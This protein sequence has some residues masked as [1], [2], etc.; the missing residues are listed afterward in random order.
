MK[1]NKKQQKTQQWIVSL[2][3]ILGLVLG[4][5]YG[6]IIPQISVY[7]DTH[8]FEDFEGGTWYGGT[9]PQ[10]GNENALEVVEPDF[11]AVS[12]DKALRFEWEKVYHNQSNR[13]TR[14]SEVR[15]ERAEWERDIWESFYYYFPEEG[16][17][18]D[19]LGTV[20]KQWIAW[21]SD[22]P[23]C[24]KSFDLE[25]ANDAL[26][27]HVLWNDE[28][29]TSMAHPHDQAYL[30]SA[31][32]PK[33]TWVK[34]ELHYRFDLD[35]PDGLL[36][37]WM[38]DMPMLQLKDIQMGVG[39]N[40]YGP[41]AKYGPYVYNS[42]TYDQRFMYADDIKWSYTP[43][44]DHS[45]DVFPDH[46]IDE[47]AW[48][49]RTGFVES[50]HNLGENTV[51]EGIQNITFDVTP[52]LN[53]LDGC[54]GYMDAS[55]L[56]TSYSSM[57]MIVRLN[58]DGYFDV[59]NGSG[60]EADTS[61]AYEHDVTY[62]V[63]IE[64]DMATQTYS[65][66]VTDEQD[67]TYSL[68]TDY[69]YRTG[70]PSIDDIGQICLI[71]S[72][73][74]GQFKVNNHRVN[75]EA[76]PMDQE[77]GDEDTTTVIVP[78]KDNRQGIVTMIM[79]DGYKASTEYYKSAFEAN[80]LKGSLA[81]ITDWVDDDPEFWQEIVASGYF[82]VQSHS[83]SHMDLSQPSLDREVIEHEVVDSKHILQSLFPGQDVLGFVA[84]ENKSNGASDEIIIETYEAMRKGVR[85]FNSLSPSQPD[86]YNLMVQGVMNTASESTMN[87][88]LDTAADNG[89]WLIEMWHGVASYNPGTYNPVSKT[90]ADNH[91]AYMGDKQEQ[92]E[93]WVATFGEAVKYIRQRQEADITVEEDTSGIQIT[94]TDDLEDSIYN[95]EV[96]LRSEVPMDWEGVEIHHNGT[97]MQKNTVIESDGKNYVYYN[98]IPDQG[99]ITLS[100]GEYVEEPVEEPEVTVYVEEDFESGLIPNDVMT[101]Y[102]KE[103]RITV[104]E[105]TA[106]NHY[107][108]VE[109]A[110]E[111]TSD[112]HIDMPLSL[113]SQEVMIEMQLTYENLPAEGNIQ[114]KD[115]ENGT[116]YLLYIKNG[117]LM[118]TD[119]ATVC[120]L[121]SASFT[122][123]KL[124]MNLKTG[125]MTVAVDGAIVVEDYRIQ[126]AQLDDTMTL[127]RVYMNKTSQSAGGTLMIDDVTLKDEEA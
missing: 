55:T 6:G 85:G 107:L 61:V 106:G 35:S 43:I 105:S 46:T 112:A 62:H 9:E 54:I 36:E 97:L 53:Y 87:G 91:L 74:D 33:N 15:T 120:Q 44:F 65:V 22:V 67:R 31:D 117:R 76:A 100:Q 99:I 96:T 75:G 23:D 10:I 118:T 24:N 38:N 30:V 88:W 98:T 86:W 40:S 104:E 72:V 115:S 110:E 102:E 92:G 58:N 108:K 71:D 103:N 70:A 89:K 101:I 111:V 20:I 123:I 45:G 8:V 77:P 29:N 80:N 32:L 121:D 59:R 69:N 17:G 73:T 12:G 41:Y 113:T 116:K 47:T 4:S 7:A 68:A 124:R 2:I 18:R 21:N 52:F 37:I 1:K 26:Y 126:N 39:I 19:S 119:Y 84:P 14:S 122:E 50:V 83:V 5:L 11:G 127:F 78:V 90:V 60:Y 57:N 63:R 93:L 64:T 28:T 94:Y 48:Y 95:E 13:G 49:G 109:M 3:L 66:W 82:D 79:D 56:A 42:S 25:V 114:Y 27:A 34:F 51:P 16:F 81:L 125:R